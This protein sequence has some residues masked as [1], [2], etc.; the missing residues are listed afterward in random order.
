MAHQK[1]IR[2][3]LTS[4]TSEVDVA[5][6]AGLLHCSLHYL[7]P[8]NPMAHERIWITEDQSTLLSYLEDRAIGLRYLSLQGKDAAEL[9]EQIK[10]MIPVVPVEAV[11]QMLDAATSRDEW[12]AAIYHAAA[13]SSEDLDPQLLSYF[14]K[15]MTHPE[16]DVRKAALFAASYPGWREL[17]GPL[18]RLRDHDPDPA[19]RTMAEM[20][21]NSLA[22]NVWDKE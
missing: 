4:A 13:V 6:V 16:P 19:V 22:Q 3:L 8:E 17:R 5:R 9:A 21:L 20:T 11:Y 10:Q 14:E 18:E 2:L 12:I 15:A 1:R 7:R